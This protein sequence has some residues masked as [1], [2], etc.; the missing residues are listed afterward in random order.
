MCLLTKS[1]KLRLQRPTVILLLEVSFCLK[2]LL[3]D[4]PL[5]LRFGLVE[6]GGRREAPLAAPCRDGILV[7]PS[8]GFALVAASVNNRFSGT[9]VYENI[10]II[11]YF[12]NKVWSVPELFHYCSKRVEGCF[13]T[14]RIWAQARSDSILRHIFGHICGPVFTILGIFH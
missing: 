4:E 7:S 10:L 13:I 8:L 5:A 12:I 9:T 1:D 14:V 2:H 6:A 3:A 11:L